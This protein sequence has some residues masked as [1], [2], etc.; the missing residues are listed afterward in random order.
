M[1]SIDEM[2]KQI[3]LLQEIL[4]QSQTKESTLADDLECTD[5]RCAEILNESG[6]VLFGSEDGVRVCYIWNEETKLWVCHKTL[7]AI[8]YQI[9]KLMYEIMSK[10]FVE[11]SNYCRNESRKTNCQRQVCE[12]RHKTWQYYTSRWYEPSQ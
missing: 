5:I 1:T 11:I 6:N 12:K 2:Q 4:K 3:D 8:K 10:K 9:S 7:P